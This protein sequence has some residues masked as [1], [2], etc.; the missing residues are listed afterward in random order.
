M[1]KDWFDDWFNTPYY[2]ILYK[3]RDDKEASQFVDNLIKHLRPLHASKMLD[4]GC[5]RG[6]HSIALQKL[7]FD[8]SGIDI[9][10]RSITEALNYENDNLHFFQHDMRQPFWI[11]YF[12]YAF[13]FFTSFGYFDTK[14]EHLNTISA[15]AQS[16]KKN[17]IFVLDY[18]NVAYI[19]ANMQHQH[20]LID[21]NLVFNITKW[22]DDKKIYKKIIVEDNTNY[23]TE[24]FT[25]VVSRFFLTDFIEMFE[26]NNLELIETYGDYHFKKYDENLS[27]RLILIAKKK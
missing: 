27:P 11:N 6:R 9:S 2:D 1:T 21:G 26:L 10:E 24:V 23:K 20:Q 3:N 15:I 25:E 7:G 16:L 18:L 19:E 12:D 14:R 4:I 22:H 8:V 13:N 17:G 5:G